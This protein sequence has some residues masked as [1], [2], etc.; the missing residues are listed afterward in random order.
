ML[1]QFTLSITVLVSLNVKVVHLVE[2]SGMTELFLVALRCFIGHCGKSILIWSEH[3]SNFIGADRKVT[4]CIGVLL[5]LNHYL[6]QKH[7]KSPPM[8]QL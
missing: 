2:V 3:G 5:S 6:F 1:V 7:E 4:F 8:H